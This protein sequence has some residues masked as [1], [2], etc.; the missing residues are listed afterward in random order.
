MTPW[1]IRNRIKGALGLGKAA[2]SEEVSLRLRLP[3]GAEHEVRCEPG[4]TLT[5]ASQTLETPIATG[6]PDGGC[7]NCAVD[8]L[9][10]T[11]LKEP[12]AAERKLLEEKKHGAGVRLACH[13]R[14]QGSGARVGV[15]TVWRM[16]QTR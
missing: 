1:G 13:A 15:R 10:P 2:K 9:D 12:S 11:G 7:G 14:V 4:Y 8:V 3:D 6:C 16:E 5:M